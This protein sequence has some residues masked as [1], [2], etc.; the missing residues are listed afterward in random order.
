MPNPRI[1]VSVKPYAVDPFSPNP[2]IQS[3]VEPYAADPFCQ[4]RGFELLWKS[5]PLT[6]FCQIRGFEPRRNSLYAADRFMPNPRIRA[7]VELYDD[8]PVRGRAR[9]K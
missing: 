2:R 4:I 3:S 9:K 8:D 5:M 1:R 7:S 6:P